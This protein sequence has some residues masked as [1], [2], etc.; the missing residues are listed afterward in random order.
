MPEMDQRGT[1]P[2]QTPWIKMVSTPNARKVCLKG[3]ERN[4][5]RKYNRRLFLDYTYGLN[6]IYTGEEIQAAKASPAFEREYNLKYLGLI[7][8]VFH[9]NDIDAA[10]EKTK[11][12]LANRITNNTYTQKSV[13]LDPRFGSSAVGIYITELVDGLVKV[14]HA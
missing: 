10:I 11:T 6:K 2:N 3:L 4:Q 5:N 7:G 14:L 8:N 12:T 9:T 1:L 13:G